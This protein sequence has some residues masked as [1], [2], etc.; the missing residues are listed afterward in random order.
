MKF[1][2]KYNWLGEIFC[3]DKFLHMIRLALWQLLLQSKC[4][5]PSNNYWIISLLN[6]LLI[7]IKCYIFTSNL[8]YAL[9]NFRKL[10]S[11]RRYSRFR[12]RV[13][14][15]V[16]FLNTKQNASRLYNGRYRSKKIKA[17]LN[18][19]TTGTIKSLTDWDF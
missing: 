15:K 11:D 16:P 18:K 9:S 1:T 12:R 2:K 6:Y 5:C 10:Q 14:L 7:Y 17:K 4:P 8:S 19:F 3:R 13:H